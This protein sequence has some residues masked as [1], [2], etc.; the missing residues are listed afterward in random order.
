MA[1]D[2]SNEIYKVGLTGNAKNVVDGQTP[3]RLSKNKE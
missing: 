2:T 1:A 3:S